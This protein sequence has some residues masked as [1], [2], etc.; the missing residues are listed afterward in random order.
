MALNRG[1]QVS[2]L[3]G[4]GL[5]EALLVAQAV[6]AVVRLAGGD[7]PPET[8]VFAAY[9][10]ISLLAVPAGTLWA[11]TDRSRYG[12]AV[13]AVACFV[14]AVLVLRLLQLWEG[15]GA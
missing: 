8:G 10:V 7:R 6:V 11:L 13:L 9:L 2:L 1:P 15:V 3:V 4:L 14:A 12:P 5:L